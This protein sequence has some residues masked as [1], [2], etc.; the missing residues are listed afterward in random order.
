M[1]FNNLKI[2]LKL[3]S[4]FGIVILIAIIMGITA[5]L[6]MKKIDFSL[7]EI[8]E[9]RLPAINSFQNLSLGI[10]AVKCS[11]RTLLIENYPKPKFENRGV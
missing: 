11:E 8:S 2:R 10:A 7:K 9:R 6:G 1:K 5:Y 4:G 3:L